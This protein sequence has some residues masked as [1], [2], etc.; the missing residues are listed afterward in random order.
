MLSLLL[1]KA[2]IAQTQLIWTH[3][4]VDCSGGI[5][6]FVQDE[7]AYKNSDRLDSPCLLARGGAD[8]S[9]GDAQ[10]G[11]DVI[12]TNVP[13]MDGD[14]RPH[15]SPWLNTQ[16]SSTRNAIHQLWSLMRVALHESFIVGKESN[17]SKRSRYCHWFTSRT[18]T[19]I[20][21]IWF[22]CMNPMLSST[23]LAGSALQNFK[24]LSACISSQFDHNPFCTAVGQLL[25]HLKLAGGIY[26]RRHMQGKL[27]DNQGQSSKIIRLHLLKF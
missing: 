2:M 18:C 14:F 8:C 7:Q 3:S 15:L 23:L 10:C 27:L 20:Q 13:F 16:P 9:I 1:P 12:F 11:C 6:Y 5:I 4:P 22:L 19:F 26:S 24:D 21:T 25:W 17:Q